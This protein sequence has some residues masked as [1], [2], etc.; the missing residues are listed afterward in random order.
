MTSSSDATGGPVS[1][2][3]DPGR[4]PEPVAHDAEVVETVVD[5]VAAPEDGRARRGRARAG[6]GFSVAD[7]HGGGRGRGE[8]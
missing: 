6:A 8:S 3:P 5:D 2:R 7:P 1:G 4:A